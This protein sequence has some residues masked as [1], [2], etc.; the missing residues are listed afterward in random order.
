[1]LRADCLVQDLDWWVIGKTTR[2]AARA[3]FRNPCGRTVGHRCAF[4]HRPE[5][6]AGFRNRPSREGR[7][8]KLR[9]VFSACSARSSHWCRSCSNFALVT[10]S[11]A[12]SADAH[13]CALTAEDILIEHSSNAA[14]ADCHGRFTLA[15]I[16]TADLHGCIGRARLTKSQNLACRTTTSRPGGCTPPVAASG[17]LSQRHRVAARGW[18][19]GLRRPFPSPMVNASQFECALRNSCGPHDQGTFEVTFEFPVGCKVMVDAA[20]RVLSLVNQLAARNTARA[21]QLR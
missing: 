5:G 2:T 8:I 10:G 4:P 13:I 1:L 17:I 19:F 20:I 3:P 16:V 21:P 12:A 15:P 9:S 6:S 18:S 11:T 14:G 7:V